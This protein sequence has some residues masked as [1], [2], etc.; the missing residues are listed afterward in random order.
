MKPTTKEDM[1]DFLW[2]YT[3]P[4]AVGAAMELG[5]FWLLA[6]Q[7]LD[8]TGV[9]KALRIPQNRCNFWLQLLEHSGF[10]E[11]TPLGYTPSSTART[12]I[13]DGY[14]QESWAFSAREARER[15][16]AVRDLALHINKAGSAWEAQ[17]LI[18]PDYLARMIE[19][20]QRAR[21][22]THMLYELHQEFAEEVTNALDMSGVERLMDLG[23]GSG[24]VSLALLGKYPN[25]TCM[26]VD[27]ENVCAVGREIAA[28]HPA[29]DRITYHAADFL[30]DELPAEFDMV[31]QCDV[32]NYKQ[33]VF[34]KAH[35][36]LNPG[37]RL[38]IVDLFA[39]AEGV[40]PAARLHWAFL[41]SLEKSDSHFS[42]ASQV[43][44]LLTQVGFQSLSEKALSHDWTL[45]VARK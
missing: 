4:L 20:S 21:E 35:A 24:V 14:S 8:A 19:S 38:A 18:P 32:G 11:K 44:T 39:P 29:G 30:Q 17:G 27:I 43:K 28:E 25:L 12:V 37:G 5:L 22:F 23:G 7:P 6:E 15:L 41:G 42:T 34:N 3:I 26:V 2:S 1:F 33:S 31:L 40:A 9:A 13:L 10:L 16:P 36:A 45:I